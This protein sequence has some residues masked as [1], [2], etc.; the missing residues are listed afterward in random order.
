MQLTMPLSALAEAIRKLD[1]VSW[2]LTWA[3]ERTDWEHPRL[4]GNRL[5][6]RPATLTIWSHGVLWGAAD[7]GEAIPDSDS[8]SYGAWM[9]TAPV[10]LQAGGG[11]VRWHADGEGEVRLLPSHGGPQES[12]SSGHVAVEAVRLL[13][14][15]MTR[16]AIEQRLDPDAPEEDFMGTPPSWDEVA[17]PLVSYFA[18]QAAA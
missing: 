2:A 15:L 7:A 13:P 17:S 5:Y 1:S 14:F 6:D 8:Y 4:Y 9:L 10:Q 3:G 16:W 11:L 18:R 12:Y